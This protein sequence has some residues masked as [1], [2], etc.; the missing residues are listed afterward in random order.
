M[1]CS[2]SDNVTST[3]FS[4][5]KDCPKIRNEKLTFKSHPNFC[6]SVFASV[7]I[8]YIH[9]IKSKTTDWWNCERDGNVPQK[10]YVEKSQKYIKT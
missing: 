8:F 9:H 7:D 1:V 5:K 10:R 6:Y 3:F 4:I 2:S